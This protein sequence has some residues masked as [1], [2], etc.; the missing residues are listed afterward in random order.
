MDHELKGRKMDNALQ[1]NADPVSIID[2]MDKVK[3]LISKQ[4]HI[5]VDRVKINTPLESL[6]LDSLDRVELMFSIEEAFNIE[7]MESDIRKMKTAGDIVLYIAYW[8]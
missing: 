6:N 2:T 4:L 8:K 1:V 7:M 5:N 3:S